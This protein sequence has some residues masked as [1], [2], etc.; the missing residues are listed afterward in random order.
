MHRIFKIYMHNKLLCFPIDWNIT[1]D[2]PL[3]HH[4]HLSQQDRLLAVVMRHYSARACFVPCVATMPPANTMESEP[5]RAARDSS[6]Y[7]SRKKLFKGL[8]K[9]LFF[10]LINKLLDCSFNI[11][12]CFFFLQRTVQKNAKYVCLADKNCPVDKRRRNRCQFCRFQKCLSVGMVKEGKFLWSCFKYWTS[13]YIVF[14]ITRK[15]RLKLVKSIISKL[16]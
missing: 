15:K 7:F 12:V 4:P 2:H 10:L 16:K 14:I 9:I 3:P 6:R 13:K 1:W 11:L 5:A 8:Q